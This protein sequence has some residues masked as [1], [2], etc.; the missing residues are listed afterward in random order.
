MP[1]AEDVDTCDADEI[2]YL[3]A[4]LVLRQS[5]LRSGRPGIV[6]QSGCIP[7]CRDREPEEILACEHP[8]LLH[9]G[10]YAYRLG[11]NFSSD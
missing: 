6:L 10:I 7:F 11:A 4:G 5:G 8:W 1:I 9:L 2:D 3:G